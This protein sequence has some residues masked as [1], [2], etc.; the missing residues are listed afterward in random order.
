[1]PANIRRLRSTPPQPTFEQPHRQIEWIWE[2]FLCRYK[3]PK[4]RE[5]G[6]ARLA[7][8]KRFLSEAG[9]N[10][11]RLKADPRFYLSVHWD[12]FAICNAEKYWRSVGYSTATIH[13]YVKG[14]KNV[15]DFAA[16]Q[17]YTSV[18]EFIYPQ[19]KVERA[20]KTREAYSDEEINS[21]RKIISEAT[22]K[23]QRIARGYKRT[24]I[25]SDPR[26][27]K[28]GTADAGLSSE[29][30]WSNWENMVWFFENVMDCKALQ[31]LEM[32]R[33]KIK[34]VQ[35]HFFLA[36]RQ[37]H[38]GIDAV[39][40]RLGVEPYIESDLIIPLAMKL[41][42]ETGLNP[43]S[44][45]NLRRDCYQEQHGLTGLPFI[46][47]HKERSGG[48]KELQ[49]ALFAGK[50]E[51][52][53]HLLPKQ[54]EII[55]RTIEL[56]LKLTEPLV[57]K[58]LP[59]DRHFLLLFE[60][61]SGQGA[62]ISEEGVMR[63][64]KGALQC[65]SK[66]VRRKLEKTSGDILE[67]LNLARFRTTKITQ[68]VR[69]GHDFFRVQAIA[70][71]ASVR[72]TARYL[73]TYQLEPEARRE[74]AKTLVQIQRNAREY[75]DAPK[76]YAASAGQFEPGFIYKGVLSDC[77][78]PYEPPKSVRRLSTYRAGES[79]SYWNMCLLC[80]NVIITRKHLPLLVS[81][82]GEIN[83]S[84][85][86]H[87]LTQVPNNAHY[88][89]VLAVISEIFREFPDEDIKWANEI[90]ESGDIFADGVTYHGVR[91][92]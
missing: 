76:P 51:A 23:A 28:S 36:A 60:T 43:N 7:A 13:S 67:I 58:A 35:R 8:Y 31:E 15:I 81:Y 87:N 89:K 17:G 85:K 57:G 86:N 72:T 2:R 48:E 32:I 33:R 40:E 56:I 27:K 47:Y 20:T 77:K 55:R 66:A 14:L 70:G 46:R 82:A 68:M 69:E 62:G 38:G 21:V 44:I 3:S 80:P 88:Q 18:T 19:I 71:H 74:V 39:W 9:G 29:V 73:A 42:W 37:Y 91:D 6:R 30:R 25:G 12:Y 52:E 10:D 75:N 34:T 64:N 61:F 92:E 54:S 84:V 24:G 22:K 53:H 11:E 41:A 65:W 1:M 79:C 16:A 49:L 45:L 83:A 63:V 5:G 90:A 78:N 50:D 26:W 4:T 59:K